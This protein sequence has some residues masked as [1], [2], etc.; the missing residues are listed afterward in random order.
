MLC[1]IYIN[2]F[3]LWVS[4]VWILNNIHCIPANSA[5]ADPRGQVL[6]SSNL[7]PVFFLHFEASWK[8]MLLAVMARIEFYL[9]L[10]KLV[11]VLWNVDARQDSPQYRTL[12]QPKNIK[13]QQKISKKKLLKINRKHQKIL[14]FKST[15]ESVLRRGGVCPWAGRSPF[16]DGAVSVLERGGVR[17]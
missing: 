17:S 12:T 4:F 2:K 1:Y 9:V 15:T 10:N 11:F 13:I 8:H 7:T 6:K 5:R 16:L 14:K 3:C